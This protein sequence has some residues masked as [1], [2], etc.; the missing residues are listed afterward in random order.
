MSDSVATRF[1]VR[2]GTAPGRLDVLR[3]FRFSKTYTLS[4]YATQTDIVITSHV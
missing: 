3:H 2:L 4:A 1:S